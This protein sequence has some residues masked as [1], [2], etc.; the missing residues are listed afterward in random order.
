VLHIDP[1]QDILVIRERNVFPH[2]TLLF[3]LLLF[4]LEDMSVELLLKS[5][6]GAVDANPKISKTPI[7]ATCRPFS[8]LSRTMLWLIFSTIKS[9]AA[10]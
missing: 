8:F 6:V 10:P 2:D 9:K 4:E 3:V 5:L 1:I 7:E